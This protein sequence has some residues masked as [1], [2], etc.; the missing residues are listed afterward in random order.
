MKAAA[1]EMLFLLP[2]V[3]KMVFVFLSKFRLLLQPICAT[4]KKLVFRCAKES[5]FLELN[6]K[7]FYRNDVSEHF[8]HQER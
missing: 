5:G 6:A 2:L 7:Y 1:L 8:E 4:V 3:K